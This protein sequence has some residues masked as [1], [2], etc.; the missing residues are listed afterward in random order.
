MRVTR[1]EL[2]SD[3]ARLRELRVAYNRAVNELDQ[4]GERCERELE[5]LPADASAA[6][7]DAITSRW[8]T[9]KEEVER[10]KHNLER[11]EGIQE[12]HAVSAPINTPGGSELRGRAATAR[13]QLRIEGVYRP[14]QGHSFFRDLYRA[15]QGIDPDARERI[16]RSHRQSIDEQEL[17]TAIGSSD[18]GGFVPPTYLAEY[19]ANVPRPARPFADVLPKVQLPDYGQSVVV[20]R[21]TG[22]TTVA[23]QGSENAA[24]SQTNTTESDLTVTVNTLAGQLDLSRQSLERSIGPGMDAVIYS[25]LAAAYDAKL[26]TYLLS[27]TGSSGEHLGI[28]GVSSINTATA[29]TP[30][31]T[32]VISEIYGQV[33][34]IASNRYRNP[35]IIVMHPRRAAWLASQTSSSVPLFQQGGLFQAF[36]QQDGGLLRTFAGCEVVLDANVGITYGNPGT[37]QDEIYIVHS[38]DLLLMEDNLRQLRFD[39]VGSGTLTCRLQVFAY[40]AF[41]SGRFPSG[42][43]AISGSALATPTFG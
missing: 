4:V 10:H 16:D 32:S 2:M 8:E 12:A 31:A 19:Y 5:R 14:D 20:P 9:A 29:S 33:S 7:I 41:A 38:P 3:Q 28:R 15:Q 39:D 36:G 11:L 18:V 37:N 35:D 17:R 21:L 30:T 34:T 23:G 40:S 6:E 24:V 43:S 13:G 26:D 1:K 42:I 27:G 25:D 22:G